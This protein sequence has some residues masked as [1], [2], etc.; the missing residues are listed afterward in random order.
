MGV[1]HQSPPSLS[2]CIPNRTGTDGFSA[3][4]GDDDDDW[5]LFHLGATWSASLLGLEKRVGLRPRAKVG[6]GR[7]ALGL[8]RVCFCWPWVESWTA[9]I[10]EHLFFLPG[11]AAASAAWDC[12]NTTESGTAAFASSPTFSPQRLHSR[13]TCTRKRI[14]A[15]GGYTNTNV[16]AGKHNSGIS[17]TSCALASSSSAIRSRGTSN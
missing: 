12:E 17:S 14:S 13:P 3:H 11:M 4:G 1:S 7:S 8:R 9:G 15:V 6:Q 2:T 16:R 5:A 10:Q